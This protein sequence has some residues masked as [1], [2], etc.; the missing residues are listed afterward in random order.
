M[1]NDT[2]YSKLAANNESGFF[3]EFRSKNIIIDKTD[4]GFKLTLL[5]YTQIDINEVAYDILNMCTGDNSIMKIIDDMIVMY[6]APRDLIKKDAYKVLYDFWTNGIIFWKDNKNFYATLYEEKLEGGYVFKLPVFN[7]SL[8]TTEKYKN[9]MIFD[10]R[11]SAD[12]KFTA[13][14]LEKEVKYNETR[15][16]ECRYNDEL[17]LSFACTPEKSYIED[18]DIIA[19]GLDGLYVNSKEIISAKSIWDKFMKWSLSW[20]DGFKSEGLKVFNVLAVEENSSILFDL[21]FVE[22]SSDGFTE[23][24]F[25]K[26]LD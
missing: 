25:E 3:P 13:A 20:F 15:F 6:E 8:A 2:F 4:D 11:Y 18:S 1:N 7:E 16:F 22:I 19:F 5:N 10:Q 23:K 21:G 24:Y 26:S 9:D 12:I 17:I 14:Y